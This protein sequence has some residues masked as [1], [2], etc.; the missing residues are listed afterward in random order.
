M[1]PESKEADKSPIL[2]LDEGGRAPS[3]I[4]MK[5]KTYENKLES[6]VTLKAALAL[7]YGFL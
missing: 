7:Q 6:F 5:A 4:R 2:L 1:E 3:L